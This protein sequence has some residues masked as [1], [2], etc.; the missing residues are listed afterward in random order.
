MDGLM[1]VDPG[2]TIVSV[3]RAMELLTGYSKKELI[4]KD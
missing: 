4:G 3:N 1:V 2:G